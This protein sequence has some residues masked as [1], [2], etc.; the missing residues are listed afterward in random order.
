MQHHQHAQGAVGEG[1]GPVVAG[2]QQVL[3]DLRG[4]AG[5]GVHVDPAREFGLVAR[6]IR[7]EG[8]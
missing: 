4:E 8:L 1:E 6:A 3:A 2:Y 5:E 7:W